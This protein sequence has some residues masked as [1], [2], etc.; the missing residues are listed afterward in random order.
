[1]AHYAFLNENNIVTEVI[2]GKNEGEEGIDWEAHYGAFRGQSCKRTS[3][4]THAG[5][6]SS[7]GTPYR[8][9]YAGIG[10]TY[11]FE[12]D[13]FIPLKPFA[14]WIL[15]EDSCLWDAPVAMPADAGT[16]EPPKRYSWDETTVAW[17]ELETEVQDGT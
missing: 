6:H 14:S 9:N 2:V 7:G 3:Y 17:V 15:N 16:G 13:A 12:R 8:K 4:N 10:Y 1:M 5:V 11:D